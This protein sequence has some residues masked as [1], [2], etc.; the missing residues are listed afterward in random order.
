MKKIISFVITLALSTSVALQAGAMATKEP[1]KENRGKVIDKSKYTFYEDFSSTKASQKPATFTFVSEAADTTISVIKDK[2]EDGEIKNILKV[3]DKN[4]SGNAIFDIPINQKKGKVLIETKFKYVKTTDDFM[5]FGFD[6]M[7]S[8][9]TL[10]RVIQ[11]S[12]GG[13]MN[14]YSNAG[15]NTPITIGA[16]VSEAWYTLEI[17]L[18]K[19]SG[20][21]DVQLSSEALKNQSTTAAIKYDPAGG[22]TMLKGT[23][24]YPEAAGMSVNS[25]RVQTTSKR[26]ELYFE[27]FRVIDGAGTLE[28]KGAKPEPLPLPMGKAPVLNA[29]KGIVNVNFKGE[30]LFFTYLPYEENNNVFIPVKSIASA[31]KLSVKTE[32]GVAT[33]GNGAVIDSNSGNLTVNGNVTENA[34]ALRNGVVYVSVIPFAEAMG[35]KAYYD[36]EVVITEGE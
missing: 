27:Y 17:L 31:Y 22:I 35:D 21:F 25:L 12:S 15:V 9:S 6:M 19:D 16:P 33:L 18:D 32:N 23:S 26:G 5:S 28:Y 4:A 30:Y 7:N 1:C 34:A 36:N 2:N 10:G 3:D 8:N 29:L 11:W 13:T 20:T 14:V 24:V